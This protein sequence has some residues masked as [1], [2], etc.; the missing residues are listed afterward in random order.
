MFRFVDFL[1]GKTICHP[2][3]RKVMIIIFLGL[4]W[5]VFALQF[6][7]NVTH[8]AVN[9]G[10]V[11]SELFLFLGAAALLTGMLVTVIRNDKKRF[12][13]ILALTIFYTIFVQ[14]IFAI[15]HFARLGNVVGGSTATIAVYIVFGSLF[16]TCVVAYGV[17]LLLGGLFNI[18]VGNKMARVMCLFI[19]FF[20]LL[21]WIFGLIIG[22]KYFNMNTAGLIP[23]WV[24]INPLLFAFALLLFPPCFAYLDLDVIDLKKKKVKKVV[25]YEEEEEPAPA[26]KKKA[27]PVVDE[28]EE[29]EEPAPK[30]AKPIVI[31]EEEEEPRPAKKAS[32]D[33]ILEEPEPEEEEE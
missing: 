10:E 33:E 13:V 28:E 19:L 25:I 8:N 24:F 11:V 30:K 27:E 5:L 6:I 14:F 26:P 3:A 9:A 22:S 4:L 18:K 16:W 31:E 21:Y 1:F 23:F 17:F 2:K 32:K 29:E 15:L 20:G 7:G 12:S